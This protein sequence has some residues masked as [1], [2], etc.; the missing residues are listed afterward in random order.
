M[1]NGIGT[2][3]QRSEQNEMQQRFAPQKTRGGSSDRSQ[4]MCQAF[5]RIDGAAVG[6]FV[7]RHPKGLIGW[8]RWRCHILFTISRGVAC[9]LAY[10]TAQSSCH[11]RIEQLMKKIQTEKKNRVRFF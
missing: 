5:C 6:I 7:G 3:D 1:Q 11:L 9:A 8:Q 4:R 2:K 10:A